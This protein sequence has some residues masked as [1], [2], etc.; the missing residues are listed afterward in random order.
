MIHS[1]EI[2]KEA[3]ETETRF[4]EQTEDEIA[5]FQERIKFATQLLS[6]AKIKVK[7]IKDAIVK[8]G[9]SIEPD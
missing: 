6:G 9:G 2:L 4:V 3:L 8:L 1:I 5:K 7:N